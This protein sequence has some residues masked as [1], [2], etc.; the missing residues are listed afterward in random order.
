MIDVGEESGQLV[1]MLNKLS[2]FYE[3]RVSAAVKAFAT[4][5]EPLLLIFMGLI[6]GVLVIAM[7]MPIFK[8]T[9]LGTRGAG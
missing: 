3:K 5:F 9:Q 8:L 1:V 7:F 6:I 4:V 2:D